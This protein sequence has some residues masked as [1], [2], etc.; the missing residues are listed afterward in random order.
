M[1]SECKENIYYIAFFKSNNSFFYFNY[2]TFFHVFFLHLLLY[3]LF[4][5]AYY[6]M[7]LYK[8]KNYN[9][10][11]GHF[12]YYSYMYLSE[13]F[14]NFIIDTIHVCNKRIFSFLGSFFILLLSYN[15]AAL[16]PHLEDTTKDLNVCL[17]FALY[18]VFY[19]QYI[20]IKEIGLNY[21]EHWTM[22]LLYPIQSNNKI[23]YYSSLLGVIIVNTIASILTLPFKILETVSLLFSLTFRLFGNIFGGSIVVKLLQKIQS[24]ALLYYLGTTLFGIQLIVLFYFGLFEG[25]IQAFVFTLDLLNNIGTLINKKN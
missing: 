1:L 18:G 14:T 9:N 21:L 5:I 13:L 12:I 23:L 7:K 25:V 17:A 20:S 3:I 8:K 2:N 16:I 19:I 6:F 4:Y 15:C 10:E 22:V 24:V 11:N